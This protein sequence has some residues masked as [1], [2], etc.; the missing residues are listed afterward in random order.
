VAINKSLQA[1]SGQAVDPAAIPHDAN[2]HHED[3]VAS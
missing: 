3:P 2:V 1:M